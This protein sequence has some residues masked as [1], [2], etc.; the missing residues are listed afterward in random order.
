LAQRFPFEDC[1][2][3][4]VVKYILRKNREEMLFVY[5]CVCV[6]E[7]I[8]YCLNKQKTQLS[9]ALS[10]N[11][12]HHNDRIMLVLTTHNIQLRITITTTKSNPIHNEKASNQLFCICEITHPNSCGSQINT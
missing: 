7:F 8:M 2:L 3:C 5:D 9:D 4:L 6:C 11:R 10:I 1:S 12:Q